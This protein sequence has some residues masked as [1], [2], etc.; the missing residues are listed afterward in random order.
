MRGIR[1]KPAHEGFVSL[2]NTTDKLGIYENMCCF[3]V[4]MSL[5]YDSSNNV[6]FKTSGPKQIQGGFENH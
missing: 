5:I 2:P 1:Y 3:G 6:H 4:L